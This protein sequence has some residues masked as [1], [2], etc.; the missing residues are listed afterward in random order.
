MKDILVGTWTRDCNYRGHSR[1][2]R[3]HWVTE[4]RCYICDCSD[5]R[6]M[7]LM[8]NEKPVPDYYDILEVNHK[9]E[10]IYRHHFTTRDKANECFLSLMKNIGGFQKV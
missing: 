10:V 9:G 7:G 1:I 3:Y 6:K 2:N 8:I 4:I 5:E